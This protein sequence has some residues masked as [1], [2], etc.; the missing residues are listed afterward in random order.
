MKTRCKR[1]LSCLLLSATAAASAQDF[2]DRPHYA[3]L[4]IGNQSVDQ[5][6]SLTDSDGAD[7]LANLDK[8][9]RLGFSFQ[10]PYGKK[11]VEYGWD[12]SG[13]LG[14]EKGPKL[15]FLIDDQ[16]SDIALRFDGA[17]WLANIDWGGFV[18]ARP[19]SW[20]RF[21]AS[22]GPSLYYG[23]FRLED[24]QA[25]TTGSNSVVI[26]TRTSDNHLGVAAYGRLGFE[27]I[28]SRD[29]TLGISA[30]YSNV[31]YDFGNS[32]EL[33]LTEPQ[34]FLTLGRSL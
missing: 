8:V 15:F 23:Q 17:L 31:R 9:R 27:L 25:S 5:A 32:G 11:T 30:R 13:S 10:A 29:F 28:F 4:W 19:V 12:V 16:H 34:F 2:L 22:A 20:L 1:L 3:Q 6:W 14:Y 21:Y 7:Y 26:D 24:S 33:D 18:S